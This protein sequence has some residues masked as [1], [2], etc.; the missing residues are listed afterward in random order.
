MMPEGIDGPPRLHIHRELP[1]EE[2]A[3]VEHLPD[4]RLSR[5][6]VEI[7][8]DEGAAGELEPPRPDELLEVSA[9][10][11]VPVQIGLEVTGLIEGEPELRVFAEETQRILDV[12]KAE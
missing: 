2:L 11:G 7:G 3:T 9:L 8:H 4:K 10:F 1:V 12:G 6:E 5:G